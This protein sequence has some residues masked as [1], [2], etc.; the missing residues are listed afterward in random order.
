MKIKENKLYK[1]VSAFV[2]LCGDKK[3]DMYS[4]ATSFYIFMSF[5]PYLLIIFST[6][7]YLPFSRMD[8]L[9]FIYDL[10]PVEPN[11]IIAG[12]IDEMY[13]RGVAV[14]SFSIIA[15]L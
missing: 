11:G 8:L 3:L 10:I 15:A 6:V 7:K 14:L 1:E 2:A 9:N 13:A 4:A 12:I 5:I